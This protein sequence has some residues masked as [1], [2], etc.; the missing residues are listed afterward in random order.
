M[1]DYSVIKLTKEYYSDW[2]KF[3]DSS[4]QGDIFCYSWWLDSVTKS[5]YDIYAII[6][7]EEIVAGLPI[8]YDK[9]RK[10]NELPFT[11]TLGILFKSLQGT[12]QHRRTSLERKW[13]TLLL[14]NINIKDFRQFCTHHNFSDW[15]PF[16]WK[17]LK[18]TTRYTYLL[19]YEGKTIDDLRRN[20]NRG[21][22]SLINKAENAGITVQECDDFDLLYHYIEMTFTR[23]EKKFSMPF[24]E[25]KA[26]DDSIRRNGNRLILK[27]VDQNANIHAIN[28]FAYNQKSAY[29]L[30]SGSESAFSNSG[31]QSLILFEAIKYFYNK[32]DHF[33]FGGSDIK[34]IEEHFRGF[35]GIQTPY[36]HIYNDHLL[37]D[38]DLKYNINEALFYFS[39]A[40][41][42][43]KTKLL[44]KWKDGICYHS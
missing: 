42:A 26:L 20:L 23:Q 10:I 34:Q 9:Y 15:L 30:V 37:H 19:D 44:Q 11:R 25:M 36:F 22:K 39:S 35:G 40:L 32:V 21:K 2:N 12:D 5:H 13:S 18:Q 43:M 33:N 1:A 16:K 8:A 27:A 24:I 38:N 31:G 17:G 28:Y 6:E 3:V 29:Y 4:Q 14:E 7:K 41:K